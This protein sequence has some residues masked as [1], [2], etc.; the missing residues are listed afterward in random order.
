MPISGQQDMKQIEVRTSKLSSLSLLP[1]KFAARFEECSEFASQICIYEVRTSMQAIFEVRPSI[2][3]ISETIWSKTCLE[4]FE[5]THG[6]DDA[7]DDEG[8]CEGSRRKPRNS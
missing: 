7:T 6:R 5:L 2:S 1:D 4:C 8:P 3:L